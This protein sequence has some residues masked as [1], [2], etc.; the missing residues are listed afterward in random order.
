MGI[1]KRYWFI[2]IFEV[3][4]IVVKFS[5]LI[6]AYNEEKYI[7]RCINSIPKQDN[8]EIWI[9]DDCSTDDTYKILNKL[10][11]RKD[12]YIIWHGKNEGRAKTTS[13]LLWHARGNIILKLDADMEIISKDIFTKLIDIYKDGRVGGVAIFGHKRGFERRQKGWSRIEFMVY[14]MV[15]RRKA[16]ILPIDNLKDLKHPLD[17]HCW[18]KELVPTIPSDIIHDDGYAALEILRQGYRIV[19]GNIIIHHLKPPS[20]LKEMYKVRK[21]GR[22]GW[23]QL[24]KIFKV[25]L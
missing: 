1:G 25:K 22:E 3:E 15:D 2:S 20:S 6:P 17:I 23:K 5:I 7:E 19:N 9:C 16:K 12:T 11:K 24:E 10:D 14:N 8:V 4:K 18:R 21:R 13:D